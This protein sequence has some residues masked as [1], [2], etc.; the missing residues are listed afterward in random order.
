MEAVEAA[1]AIAAEAAESVGT[2]SRAADFPTAGVSVQRTSAE[3]RS[4]KPS[5]AMSL[6]TQ[7]PRGPRFAL[8]QYPSRTRSIPEIRNTTTTGGATRRPSQV[9]SVPAQLLDLTQTRTLSWATIFYAGAHAKRRSAQKRSVRPVEP[10]QPERPRGSGGLMPIL[11][12][13]SAAL[14]A[15]LLGWASFTAAAAE[16]SDDSPTPKDF[17]D[18]IAALDKIDPNAPAALAARL[19]YADVLAGSAGDDCRQRLD[20]AQSILDGVDARPA[21]VVAFPGGRARVENT[22][23]R[24]HLALASCGGNP[25]NR[26]SELREAIGAAQRAVELYRDALDYQSAAISQFNAANTHRL[27][28][29]DELSIAA[30]EIAIDMDRE[31]GFRQDAEDNSRLLRRWRS[32]DG[33][34]AESAA[35]GMQD[36]PPRSVALKFGWTP[37]DADAEIHLDFSRAAADKVDRA[38]GTATVK[39]HIRKNHRPWLESYEPI[40]TVND[41]DVK[42]SGAADLSL[43]AVLFMRGLRQHP[44]I[45]VS[46][47]GDLLEVED[48][49]KV[50]RQLSAATRALIRDRAPAGEIAARLSMRAGDEVNVAFAP[51]TIEAKA[52]EDYSLATGAWIGAT[53]DQGVWYR[54][55]AALIMPGIDNVL[56]PNDMEFAYTRNVRCTADSAAPACVEIVLH[57]TPQEKPLGQWLEQLALTLQLPRGRS[58]HYWSTSY[59]RIVT[60]PNTLMTYAT[61]ARRYWYVSAGSADP[62]GA[63]TA[64]ETIVSTFV[65]H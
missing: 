55:S 50:A 38:S 45:V 20:E 3:V 54:M 41:A 14:V 58:V 57:A 31:Y 15:F 40:T 17:E 36:F 16:S 28:G 64:S 22:E 51:D 33:A 13:I 25:P 27:L 44:D 32:G 1:A 2:R 26:D 34:D 18:A 37:C 23:Y 62:N 39:S 12:P 65:Y 5:A 30:L 6:T 47:N 35:G 53:L 8:P 56:L 10:Q 29:D 60:D 59:L 9:P 49:R 46:H 4:R 43:L 63:T 52:E 48:S 42:S 7:S 21:F 61:D 24:V 11:R 19:E